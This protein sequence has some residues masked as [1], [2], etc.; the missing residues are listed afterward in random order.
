[1]LE[2]FGLRDDTLFIYTTD[3]GEAYPRA[4]CT[5][6]DPGIKTLLLISHPNSNFIKKGT[7]YEQLAS[8][9]D[10]MPTLLD[11]IGA[12]LPKKIEGKS[13]LPLLKGKTATFRKEIYS[14]KSFH[15]VYDP[16]RSIRTEKFKFIMNFG[17][18]QDGYQI[19]ADMR[20]DALGKYFLNIVDKARP[21]EELYDLINDPSEENNLI[22]DI[23]YKETMKELKDKLFDWMRRTED[24]ILKGKIKDQRSEPPLKY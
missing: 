13:F 7:V 11:L 12:E 3:H 22:D 8:N 2:E 9:I 16:I 6:Y 14:E 21:N 24:Q 17:K 19:A 20:Q 5:L 18:N 15:E 10:L 23:N 1:M 4:K